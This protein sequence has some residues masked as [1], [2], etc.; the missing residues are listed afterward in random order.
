MVARSAPRP[1]DAELA[2]LRVLWEHGPS[3]VRDVHDVLSRERTFAYT[4]TLKI[5][6]IT[7]E[8]GL[9]VREERGR[10]HLYRA[11]HSQ[12]AMQRTLIRDLLDR[13]FGGSMSTLVL[14]ALATRRAS[15][16]ELREIRRL[17]IASIK[18]GG[19]D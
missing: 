2:V 7:T 13:A 10:Q 16:E 11:R 3:S 5:L 9:T 1:T 19:N 12:R 6:Q 15:P 18:E 8:K 4:T 14:Q 17:T